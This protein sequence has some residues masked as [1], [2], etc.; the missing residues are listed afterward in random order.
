MNLFCIYFLYNDDQ[1]DIK[2][3]VLLF[4]TSFTLRYVPKQPPQH[5][6]II[7]SH[8]RK[9]DWLK[10]A[11]SVKGNERENKNHKYV[12]CEWDQMKILKKHNG[13]FSFFTL[14]LLIFYTLS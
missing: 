11:N 3:Y 2:S 6:K 12:V 13:T 1:Y 5:P 7:N 10:Q 8:E 14:V 9:K 4:I